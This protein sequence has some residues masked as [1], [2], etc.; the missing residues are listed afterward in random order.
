MKKTIIL[1]L[2]IIMAISLCA[3]A[4]N[5][6]DSSAEPS[7]QGSD[8]A[9]SDSQ[10][11]TMNSGQT[12]AASLQKITIKVS[13]PEGWKPVE[14]S[15]LLVQYLKNTS[16]FMVKEENFTSDSLDSIVDEAL[17]F[18][19]KSFNDLKVQGD[20]ENITV[21]GKSEQSQEIG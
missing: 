2:A 12:E 20:I 10:T 15:V 9:K 11:D 16:S 3:C 6:A 13:P 17:E 4:N 14:G 8:N 5:A 18:Y 1:S 7:S 19:E 21:D